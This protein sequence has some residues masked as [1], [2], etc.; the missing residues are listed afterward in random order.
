MINL[1]K[2]LP[3]SVGVEPATSWS[4]VGRCIKLSH[5]GRQQGLI[6]QSV[7]IDQNITFSDDPRLLVPIFC[8][9]WYSHVPKASGHGTRLY[10]Y[11]LFRVFSA[12]LNVFESTSMH[13]WTVNAKI[14][15]ARMNRLIGSSGLS[16]FVY[17][18]T[19]T[20]GTP[21]LLAILVLK[22]EIVHFT[23]HWCV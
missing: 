13:Q 20:I 10:F 11:L 23:I 21:Y 9:T 6:F 18:I 19:L 5:R 22:F 12:Q 7:A 16:L 3:T 2:M 14:C 4:P 1:H 15:I 8:L 17:R